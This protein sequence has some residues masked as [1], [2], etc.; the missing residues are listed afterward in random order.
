MTALSA[1]GRQV[2]IRIKN[3]NLRDK[4][5]VI[6]LPIKMPNVW[7]SVLYTRSLMLLFETKA[8]VDRWCDK[9]DKAKS[10][11]RPIEQIWGF[12]RG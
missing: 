7:G 8:D 10:D 3:G 4:D 1:V 12:A 11:I 2:T 9:H 5:D 6:R